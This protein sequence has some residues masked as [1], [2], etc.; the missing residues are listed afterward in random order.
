MFRLDGKVALITGAASGIGEATARAFAAAGAMVWIADRDAGNGQRVAASLEGDGRRAR[1]VELDVTREEDCQ[2]AAA[3]V[4]AAH[5][6]LDVLVNNAGIGHV[7]TIA[8]TTAA[9]LDRLHAV[10]V[11]GLFSVTKAFIGP[12]LARRA[13]VIVNMAS[14]A[15]VL[16]LRD[17]LAYC[18]TKAAVVGLTKAMAMD[19]ATDGIRINCVCPGRVMTPWVSA[20]IQE[21][22]DP[23]AALKEMASTQAI[24]RMGTPE[25][26]AAAVLYL[27]SDEAAF[28]TGTALLIDGGWSMGK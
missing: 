5:G 8:T 12:M 22:P 10:N 7:G 24:G 1:F 2:R 27:A 18:T 21:Y 19:H 6:A 14:N 11:R 9:D 3:A 25:E 26:I 4:A 16:G 17:R 28:I 23:D 13:G 15:G 20:R